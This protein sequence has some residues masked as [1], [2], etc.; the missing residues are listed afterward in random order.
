MAQPDFNTVFVYNYD[1]GAAL[2]ASNWLSSVTDGAPYQKFALN[3]NF[4]APVQWAVTAT[5]DASVVNGFVEVAQVESSHNGTSAAISLL[6]WNGAAGEP[7]TKT[8]TFLQSAQAL[9]APWTIAV[10][11]GD[12]AAHSIQIELQ[13]W[14]TNP[15]APVTDC[16]PPDPLVEFYLQQILTLVQNLYT[17]PAG[18]PSTKWTA[19][20]AHTGLSG[21]G[22][23]N[24][25]IGVT[26]IRA[27]FTSI[28]TDIQVTPGTPTFYWSL[29]FVTPT[30]ATYPLRSLRT[31]FST[32]DMPLPVQADGI[33]YTFPPGV[34]VTLTELLPAS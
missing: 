8:V 18:A 26:G 6:N 29:G 12:H 11:N 21:T 23:F 32:Q 9:V 5:I 13:L 15:N 25:A 7:L 19:G 27:Q 2:L 14:C 17:A 22:S 33:S 28:P 34:Q 10:E 1:V 20:A 24:L 3:S 31:V 16:C 30:A 4:P